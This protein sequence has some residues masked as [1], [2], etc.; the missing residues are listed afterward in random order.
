MRSDDVICD[1]YQ[2]RGNLRLQLSTTLQIIRELCYQDKIRLRRFNSRVDGRAN[3]TTDKPANR[4][5]SLGAIVY[6][7]SLSMVRWLYE[8]SLGLGLTTILGTRDRPIVATIDAEYRR[9]APLE[10][11]QSSAILWKFNESRTSSARAREKS[12]FSFKKT[13]TAASSLEICIATMKEMSILDFL[14]DATDFAI[15]NGWSCFFTFI[16]RHNYFS[17]LNQVSRNIFENWVT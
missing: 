6:R 8:W 16:Y 3:Q 5:C 15:A 2:R 4:R 10:F 7:G 13:K 14:F 9:P 11:P 17:E 1:R 12:K